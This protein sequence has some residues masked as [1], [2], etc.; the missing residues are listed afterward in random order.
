MTSSDLSVLFPRNGME[1]KGQLCWSTAPLGI[2][3]PLILKLNFTLENYI[4]HRWPVGH[5]G[6]GAPCLH[7]LLQ[8]GPW[9]LHPR[10]LAEI[11]VPVRDNL[12]IRGS[13]RLPGFTPVSHLRCHWGRGGE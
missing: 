5:H 11:L 12:G 1:G 10:I 6:F 7:W 8:Q 9:K 3:D 13:Q 2:T 4:N